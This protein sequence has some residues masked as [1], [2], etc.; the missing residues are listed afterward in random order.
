ML[1]V[2]ASELCS[3]SG[4]EI[5]VT[6]FARSRRFR[7][8]PVDS[9]CGDLYSLESHLPNSNGLTAEV[10]NADL[11]ALGLMPGCF[12]APGMWLVCFPR[13]QSWARADSMVS[14]FCL[15]RAGWFYRWFAKMPGAYHRLCSHFSTRPTIGVPEGT[16][17]KTMLSGNFSLYSR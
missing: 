9:P 15:G 7:E 13:T 17:L 16:V 4:E 14:P 3:G 11:S 10:I 2:P 6:A 12:M 5:L 8:L 1:R